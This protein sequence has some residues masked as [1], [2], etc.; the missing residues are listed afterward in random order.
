LATW[1]E[2]A[3]A[4]ADGTAYTKACVEWQQEA[5]RLSVRAI[6]TGR[7]ISPTADQGDLAKAQQ[8]WTLRATKDHGQAMTEIASQF[9]RIAMTP[10]HD[11]GH[12]ALKTTVEG[13]RLGRHE[14]LGN[15]LRTFARE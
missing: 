7:V 4:W 6:K 12:P 5:A 15:A 2:F 10:L 1:N 3:T 9:A 14:V 11:A 13:G 8:D